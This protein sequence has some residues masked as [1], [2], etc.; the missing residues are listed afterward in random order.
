MRCVFRQFLETFDEDTDVTRCGKVSRKVVVYSD[1][2]N[3]LRPSG[4][5]W[6][7][8]NVWCTELVNSGVSELTRNNSSGVPS[9]EILITASCRQRLSNSFSLYVTVYYRC[10]V[11]FVDKSDICRVCIVDGKSAEVLIV[12]FRARKVVT[13]RHLLWKVLGNKTLSILE[14]AIQLIFIA[15]SLK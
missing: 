3:V 13:A 4:L 11:L 10:W 14:F 8:T 1:V 9:V 5:A 15:H 2:T 7:L 6:I 12:L